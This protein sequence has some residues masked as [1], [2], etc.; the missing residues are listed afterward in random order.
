M[1][2]S[3]ILRR[4]RQKA[5]EYPAEKDAQFARVISRVKTRSMQQE[6]AKRLPEKRG[7]FSGLTRAEIA[8]SRTCETD[9]V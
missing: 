6:Q 9:W 3:P 2:Y 5:F 7:P 1:N 4:L 8:A